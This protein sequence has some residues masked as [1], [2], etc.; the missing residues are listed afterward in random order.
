M[1]IPIQQKVEFKKTGSNKVLFIMKVK[2]SFLVNTYLYI[3]SGTPC[4]EPWHML[5]I[6]CKGKFTCKYMTVFFNWDTM[7]RTLV[8]DT[9]TMYILTGTPCI[10][11]WHMLLILCMY[12]PEPISIKV[13]DND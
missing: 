9:D 6:L 7:Y 2:L 13:I 5:L 12:R 3:L 10:E 1:L 11:P 4:I 8:Y